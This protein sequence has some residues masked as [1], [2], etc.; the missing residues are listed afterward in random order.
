[1][2]F[3]F[4]V[5]IFGFKKAIIDASKAMKGGMTNEATRPPKR[6]EDSE[7]GRRSGW[8]RSCSCLQEGLRNGIRPGLFEGTCGKHCLLGVRRSGCLLQVLQSLASGPRAQQH[9]PGG[10]TARGYRA[11]AAAGRQGRLGIAIASAHAP[12]ISFRAHK[13]HADI[14]RLL[15]LFAVAALQPL[16]LQQVPL[17]EQHLLRVARPRREQFP[18]HL[19]ARVRGGWRGP[20]MGTTQSTGRQRR[21][22]AGEESRGNR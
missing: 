12:A 3:S 16:A 20:E 19:V 11:A 21:G 6:S 15:V 1:M 13:W 4:W 8:R 18:I 9:L 10:G 5:S 14:Q 17:A 7:E 2:S 22:R